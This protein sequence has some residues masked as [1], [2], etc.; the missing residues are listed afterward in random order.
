MARGDPPGRRLS[1]H[2]DRESV[3]GTVAQEHCCADVDGKGNRPGLLA[4]TCVSSVELPGIEPSA[5]IALT[6]RNAVTYD[7]KRRESTRNDLRIRDRC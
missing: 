3:E 5:E 6:W 7:A 1:A 2:I 4:L